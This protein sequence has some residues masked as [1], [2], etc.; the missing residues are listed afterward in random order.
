MALR[1]GKVKSHNTW[2]KTP[3][4]RILISCDSALL[5]SCW[6]RGFLGEITLRKCFFFLKKSLKCR[7]LDREKER[8]YSKDCEYFMLEFLAFYLLKHITRLKGHGTLCVCVYI[9]YTILVPLLLRKMDS[10]CY[11]LAVVLPCLH[12]LIQQIS[13]D[14]FHEYFLKTL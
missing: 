14:Y 2:I 13:N 3:H 10:N 5:S 8:S 7:P 12:I 11:L 6:K 1:K 4:K 9:A